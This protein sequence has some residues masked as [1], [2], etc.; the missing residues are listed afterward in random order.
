[1]E[2]SVIKTVEDF[3]TALPEFPKR[4]LGIPESS[5]K[6]LQIL[7]Q[8]AVKLPDSYKKSDLQPPLII[9]YHPKASLLNNNIH[10]AYLAEKV[11]QKLGMLPIWIPY[12]Y[13]TGFK[14]AAEKIRRPTYVLF[15]NKYIPLRTSA[16][17][18]GNII[19]TEKA[20]SEREVKSFFRELEKHEN[21]LL[22]QFKLMLNKFNFGHY[23]FDLKRSVS[24]VNKKQIHQ[25]I[26]HYE[27]LWLGSLKGT[28]KLDEALAN[29]S[30]AMLKEL[31][32][33][34]GLAMMD[35]ILSEFV[36]FIFKEVLE[37]DSIKNDPSILENLF[38]AYD[39]KSR[40]RTPIMYAG[41]GNFIAYNDNAVRVFDGNLDLLI[42]GLKKHTV[43]PTGDLIM[44]LFT[45]IGCKL[46][47]G[48]AHTIE[49]YPDYFIKAHSILKETSFNSKMQLLSYGKIRFMDLRNI[50]DIMSSIRVFDKVG[51]RN[52]IQKGKFNLPH[53]VVDHLNFLS[54]KYEVPLEY[55]KI[56]ENILSKQ[57]ENQIT[58]LQKEE[59]RYQE[60]MGIISKEPEELLKEPEILKKWLRGIK[61]NELH[62]V[63]LEILLENLRLDVDTRLRLLKDNIKYEQHILGGTL[64]DLEEG[65][66]L[67]DGLL[68]RSNRYPSLLELVFY[69][70]EPSNEFNTHGC[71][72]DHDSKW[73]W[74]TF[75]SKE[76]DS[77]KLQEF[78]DYFS[79]FNK[80]I[81]KKLIAS[82]FR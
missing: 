60:V 40:E 55:E 69:N 62:P 79:V 78:S 21:S 72:K 41:E 25:N 61:F 73:I 18:R 29:I 66:I 15:E 56:L 51:S 45:A 5:Q 14:N 2:N 77:L 82:I 1:M 10:E 17:I 23:L 57:K 48:G 3:I 63:K 6:L 65:E 64:Y 26:I 11:A 38:L 39:I 74:K 47:L 43:L 50:I 71:L 28:K 52:Y 59:E 12:I 16:A 67:Y 75:E 37:T 22:S 20:I 76:K 34:I 49:Y 81:P 13:D 58:A 9:S 4:S 36:D 8:K 19:A 33:D 42:D 35:D 70:C 31:N 54:G 44:V 32:I 68:L 27:N 24:K 53:D 30:V 7:Y 80:L 46:V